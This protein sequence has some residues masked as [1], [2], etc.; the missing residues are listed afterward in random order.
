MD[1]VGI[2]TYSS[3][4]IYIYPNRHVYNKEQ[5]VHYNESLSQ[6]KISINVKGKNDFKKNVDLEVMSKTSKL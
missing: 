5:H 6:S 4:Y 3:I 2:K 1:H